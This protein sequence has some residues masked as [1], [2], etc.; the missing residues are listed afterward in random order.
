MWLFGHVLHEGQTTFERDHG[1]VDRDLLLRLVVRFVV[2]Q[3]SVH[4]WSN[5]VELVV[6]WLSSL[7]FGLSVIEVQELEDKFKPAARHD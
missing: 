5:F 1:L 3:N 6:G 4:K 7:W 2:R